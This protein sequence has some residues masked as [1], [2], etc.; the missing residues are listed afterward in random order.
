MNKIKLKSFKK[1]LEEMTSTSCVANFAMP[2]S[3]ELIKF[4]KK[5][6]DKKK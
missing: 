1:W 5:K 3:T 4:K 2:L 6:L